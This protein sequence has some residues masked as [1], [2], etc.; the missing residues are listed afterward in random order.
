MFT[1]RARSERMSVGAERIQ[2][3]YRRRHEGHQRAAGKLQAAQR[4]RRGR[5]PV[6]S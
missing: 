1:G 2:R 5:K 4:G 6:G 3:A